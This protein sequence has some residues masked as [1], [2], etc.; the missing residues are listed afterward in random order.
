MRSRTT[1]FLTR[2]LPR[3]DRSTF[4][5]AGQQ[6]S[7]N[8]KFK[9]GFARVPFTHNAAKTGCLAAPRPPPQIAPLWPEISLWANSH[10]GPNLGLAPLPRGEGETNATSRQYQGARWIWVLATFQSPFSDTQRRN[11]E[12]CLAAPCRPRRR[13]E[14]L[15]DGVSPPYFAA[16]QTGYMI[17][18]NTRACFRFADG[19]R[20]GDPRQLR[21]PERLRISKGAHEIWILLRLTEPCSEKGNAV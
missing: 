14:T 10:P 4:T 21:Q 17:M 3:F 11:Q 16:E 13:N 6:F 15:T 7:Q 18:T 19:A 20:A 1:D 5:T 12:Q 9:S 2:L 8:Q